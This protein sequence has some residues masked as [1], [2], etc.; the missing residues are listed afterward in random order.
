MTAGPKIVSLVMACRN[1][2]RYIRTALQSVLAQEP[3][4]GTRVEVVVADGMSDDGSRAILDELAAADDRVRVIDNPGKI[5]ST[6]LNSAIA[7]SRGEIVLRMDA[8]TE[9]ASDY[10]RACV[11]ALEQSGAQNVGGPA[12][13]KA[14]GWMA[15]AIAAAYHSHFACGGARFHDDAY[16]GYVDTVPYGCWRRTTLDRLGPFD[17]SLVRNQDDEYNLRLVR[18]GGR[19]WQSPRIVAIIRARRSLACSVSICNMDFGRSR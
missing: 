11:L 8:H 10:V 16:E 1:E 17:E 9:Y 12:R 19:I 2:A 3:P 7:A 4:D 6:G 18:A 5:V 14:N 13:T 15:R